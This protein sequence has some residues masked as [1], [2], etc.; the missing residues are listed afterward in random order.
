MVNLATNLFIAYIIYMV[1]TYIVLLSSK[2]SRVE[3]RRVRERLAQ[4]RSKNNL[5]VAEQR[6]FINLKNPKSKPFKWSVKS[7][8]RIV[9]NIALMLVV[10]LIV[11]GFWDSRIPVMLE[12]WQVIP[13]MVVLPMVANALL[14]KFGLEKDD[15]R[16][17]WK[18]RG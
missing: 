6:E 16:V 17:F 7:V 2:K 8:A 3:H 10:F 13:L 1:R 12:L 15:L 5:S 9:F 18:R 11:R 4:L 14:K